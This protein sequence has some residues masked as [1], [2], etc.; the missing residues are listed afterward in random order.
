M[1]VIFS[2]TL[3]QKC[4]R[5]VSQVCLI[6]AAWSPLIPN[7]LVASHC[8]LFSFSTIIGL[9]SLWWRWGEMGIFVIKQ[10]WSLKAYCSDLFPVSSKDLEPLCPQEPLNTRMLSKLRGYVIIKGKCAVET[11]V[12]R[13][14]MSHVKTHQNQAHSPS[15]QNILEGHLLQ[16]NK[17]T[18]DH[19][20]KN[21]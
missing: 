13:D 4:G 11:V 8:A 10:F 2:I 7:D 3:E 14:S 15:P 9:L 1:T 6:Q 21:F 20:R 19:T 17:T 12:A 5:R 16:G 18:C